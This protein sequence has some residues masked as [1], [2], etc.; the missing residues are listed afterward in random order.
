M[1]KAFHASHPPPGWLAGYL[2]PSHRALPP[3]PGWL[4]GGLEQVERKVGAQ[5]SEILQH[6]AR[7]PSPGLTARWRK[8]PELSKTCN[9]TMM[10]ITICVE[11][12]IV[13]QG[14]HHKMLKSLAW[15][16]R[17]PPIKAIN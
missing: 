14:P 9:T 12:I 13:T 17:G 5:V 2:S 4:T 11:V 16:T 3:S 1:T 10:M 7:P 8:T 6:H 15:R